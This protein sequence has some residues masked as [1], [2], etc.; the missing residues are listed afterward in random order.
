MFQ[1][2]I[3]YIFLLYS[4]VTLRLYCQTYPSF[5]L[6]LALHCDVIF[7]NILIGRRT[8]SIKLILSWQSH[9]IQKIINNYFDVRKVVL[10]TEAKAFIEYSFNESAFQ[11]I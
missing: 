1:F 8:T 11:L 5:S 2:S 3:A 10:P 4:D 9:S 7:Y 6:F